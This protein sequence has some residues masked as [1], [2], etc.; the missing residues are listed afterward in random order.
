MKLLA[1]SCCV[2]N[3]TAP[4]RGGRHKRVY[5][6]LL[7]AMAPVSKDGSTFRACGPSYETPPSAAPQ[8]E[9]GICG[10]IGLL[11]RRNDELR[12]AL[13]PGRPARGN[14]LGLGVE[15]DRVRP[16]L[17]EVAEARALPAAECIV[18]D[19]DRDRHV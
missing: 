15:A 18:R 19:R 11:H 7:H 3:R 13:D 16:V 9:D 6:R 5:A 4:S 12:A 8:D 2:R 14:G 10:A 1:Q 17:I